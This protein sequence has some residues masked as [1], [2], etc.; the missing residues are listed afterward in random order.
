MTS[1]RFVLAAVAA[2]VFSGQAL[3]SDDFPSRPLTYVVASAAGGI[4]DN[5]ARFL[6]KVMSEKIGQTV[7]VENKPGG[8]GIVGSEYLLNAKPDG[9]TF[10]YS[11]IGPLGGLAL[12]HRKLS[13]NPLTAFTPVHGMA[14]SPMLMVVPAD[15]PYKTLA[16]MIAYA[17]KNP[18]GLNYYSNGAGDAYHLFSEWLQ[19][20]GGFKMTQVSYRGAPQ[21]MNDLFGGSLQVMWEYPVVMMPFIQAG[22]VR[23]I[24]VTSDKRLPVLPDVPTFAEQGFPDAVFTGWASIIVP[25]AT[26]QSA[27]DKLAKAYSETL[28]DPAVIKYFGDQGAVI[29]Q[30]FSGEKLKTFVAD[31]NV[32]MKQLYE[33]AGVQPQ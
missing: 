23:A 4:A 32:K 19:Q 30:G 33:R 31:E 15:A 27:V 2:V 24:G 16:E 13:F 3:A 26:P 20:L 6:A 22:K 12:Q 11:G 7:I 9:H 17:K 1:R 29:L 25:A 28:A 10:M 21:A 14:Y 18:E 8:A 5:G